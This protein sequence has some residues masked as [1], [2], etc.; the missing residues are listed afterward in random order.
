MYL[1]NK[2]RGIFMAKKN[3]GT[4]FEIIVQKIYQSIVNFDCDDKGYKKIDVQHNI[5]LVGKSGNSHQIDVYWAFELAGHTYKTIVEVKDW[6][7]PVK[8]EQLHSFKSLL[9]DIPGFPVGYFVSKSG[10]QEGAIN[11]ARLHG[12][13]LVQIEEQ[14]HTL[15]IGIINTTTYYEFPQLA[16][17]TKWIQEEHLNDEFLQSLNI[18]LSLDEITLLNP[19]KESIRLYD[20]MCIDA[21]PYYDSPP[22]ERHTIERDL[23][24]SWY[25]LTRTEELPFI[26]LV[27]YKF[28]CYNIRKYITV[29]IINSG[30]ADYLVTA[31]LENKSFLFNP[32][33]K[34]FFVSPL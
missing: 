8:K 30:L 29:E 25:L 26:K 6:K 33:T 15:K 23:Y 28:Q 18:N 1:Y 2:K 22:G 32:L 19:A 14:N 31:L 24:G 17:D 13:K 21:V 11:F 5:S 16:V 12:I 3:T 7:T 34:E 4:P 10:F 27:G 9:D 20:L